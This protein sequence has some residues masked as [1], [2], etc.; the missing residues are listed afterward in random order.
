MAELVAAFLQSAQAGLLSLQTNSHY[1]QLN[2]TDYWVSAI[3]FGT[4]LLSLPLILTAI[5]VRL[6]VYGWR[7]HLNKLL[8]AGILG[9]IG[10][11]LFFSLP[12][13][14]ALTLEDLFRTL[15]GLVV[16]GCGDLIFRGVMRL[17]N[18]TGWF[19]LHAFCNAIVVIWCFEPTVFVLLNPTRSYEAPED[20][21][22]WGHF[23]MM[24]LH[25]YHVLAF[26]TNLLDILHHVFS[27]G[28]IGGIASTWRFGSIVPAIDFFISGL[29]GGID[30]VLL[31]LASERLIASDTE[32]RYNRWLNFAVRAPGIFFVLAAGVLGKYRAAADPLLPS[33][34]IVLLC[35]AF[36]GANALYFQQ[37]V[38]WNTAVTLSS[39]EL[40]TKSE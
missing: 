16:I 29:P 12:T 1:F 33:W 6:E 4:F 11:T 35:A 13:R 17:N 27:A 3:L 7:D 21:Q 34:P 8:I 9:W 20:S 14:R 26:R 31:A 2:W 28:L 30:Y 38:A 15:Q 32:K 10:A 37:R 39:R 5:L 22:N 25:L 23:V 36:H 24:A 19:A 18:K 40:S